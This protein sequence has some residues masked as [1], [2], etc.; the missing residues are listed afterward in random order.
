MIALCHLSSSFHILHQAVTAIAHGAKQAFT[1]YLLELVLQPTQTH[2][3]AT[4]VLGIF[5]DANNKFLLAANSLIS[6][7]QGFDKQ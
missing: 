7:G 1:K 3:Q 6:A 5:V 4:V 2:F